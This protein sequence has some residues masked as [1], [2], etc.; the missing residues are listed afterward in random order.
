MYK[1]SILLIAASALLPMPG[2]FAGTIEGKAPVATYPE[3]S[4]YSGEVGVTFANQYNTRGIIVQDEGLTYQPYLNLYAKIYEGSGFIESTS[5]IVG[6]WSDISTNGKVSGPGNPGDRFTEF[7]YGFG[8]SFNFTG[9]WSFTTFFNNWTSPADGYG[10]GQW[11]NGTFAYDDS[12]LWGDNFSLQP[13]VTVL[14]D[15][16]GDAGTGL[17]RNSWNIEPGIK[18]N[19]TLFKD[20]QT[21]LNVG[22]LV[23]AGL[24]SEFYAGETVGYVAVGPQLSTTLGFID[25]SH[26]TWTVSAGYLYYHLADTLAP[27]TGSKDEHL[28]TFKV[29]LAF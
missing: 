7:D 8:F 18:P 15:L 1:P 24:G 27:I 20:S 19:V 28:F 26:G 9:P 23:K 22:L 12:G 29:G 6:L 10:D 21:P 17:I 11:I 3:K 5:L 2:L 14:R 4:I 25:P 16:G 13:Y